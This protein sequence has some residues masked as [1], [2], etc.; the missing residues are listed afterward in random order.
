MILCLQYLSKGA[1]ALCIMLKL[2]HERIQS[3][4]FIVI[5]Q[6]LPAHRVSLL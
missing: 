2:V 6:L 1:A 4:R 3:A 5:N